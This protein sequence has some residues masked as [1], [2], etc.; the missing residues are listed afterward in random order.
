MTLTAS[1]L[2]LSDLTE[3][4][5]RA[6]ASRNGEVSDITWQGWTGIVLRWL[7]ACAEAR[8][9]GQPRPAVPQMF[10]GRGVSMITLDGYATLA[11]ARMEMELAPVEVED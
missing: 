2:Y 4:L 6:L 5:A 10:V 3:E 7:E 9:N 1:G 11:E 8:G